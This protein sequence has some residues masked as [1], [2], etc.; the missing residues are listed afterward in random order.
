MAVIYGASP[1]LVIYNTPGR[2]SYSALLVL[3]IGL[4]E[5]GARQLQR[6]GTGSY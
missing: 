5:A 6:S 1:I 4:Y 3:V 2:L